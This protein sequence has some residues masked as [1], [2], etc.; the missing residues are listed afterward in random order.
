MLRIASHGFFVIAALLSLPLVAQE[1]PAGKQDRIRI[2]SVEP[3][4]PITRG[5]ETKVAAE[6]EYTLETADTSTVNF[7][8]NSQDPDRFTM[9][10]HIE[11]RRGT[12][13][14]KVKFTI[15]PVDW[16]HRGR[17]ALPA[18]IGRGVQGKAWSP[19]A[20]TRHEFTVV[21]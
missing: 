2:V 19:T 9:R 5:V 6:I 15:I 7:G 20:S 8:F 1:P 12:S 16:A 4:G 11:I 18:T 10:E 13:R 17:F 3:S 14:I 21:P